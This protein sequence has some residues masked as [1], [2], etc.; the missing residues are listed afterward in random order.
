MQQLEQVDTSLIM[1]IDEL[2]LL[3]KVLLI[4]FWMMLSKQKLHLLNKSIVSML[5]K[6]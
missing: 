2:L 4:S 6:M 5:L 3:L 1:F